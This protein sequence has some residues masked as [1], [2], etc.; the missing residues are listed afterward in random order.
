[1]LIRWNIL[2]SEENRCIGQEL[3]I[4]IS[5]AYIKC[6]ALESPYQIQPDGSATNIHKMFSSRQMAKTFHLALTGVGVTLMLLLLA[7]EPVNGQNMPGLVSIGTFQ[8]KTF[9]RTIDH[10]RDHG[11]ISKLK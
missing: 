10:V 11:L 5:G 4:L 1:L 7:T 8:N 3:I 9:Y 6:R 2:A